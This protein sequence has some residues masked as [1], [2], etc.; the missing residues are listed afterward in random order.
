M[1]RGIRELVCAYAVLIKK[2]NIVVTCEEGGATPVI[3]FKITGV[4]FGRA[5][6]RPKVTS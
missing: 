5:P 4:T 2:L 1:G 3:G 6:P